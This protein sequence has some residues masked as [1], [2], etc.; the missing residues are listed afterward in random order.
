VQSIHVN[1]QPWPVTWTSLSNWILRLPLAP[2]P[3]GYWCKAS[4]AAACRCPAQSVTLTIEFTG[5]AESPVGKVLF[6]EIMF[7]PRIADAEYVELFNASTSATFDLSGWR[8]NGLDYT[9]PTGSR[10]APRGFLVLVKDFVAYWTA[11]GMAVPAFDSFPGNLQSDGETLTLIRPGATPADDLVVDRVTYAATLPWPESAAGQGA[12]LQLIDPAQ[13]NSRVGNWSDNAPRWRFFSFT[14]NSGSVTRFSRFSLYFDN[15]GQACLDDVALVSGTVPGV[16][17][18][19]LKN[20][21]FESPLSPPWIV[22]P[23]GLATNSAITHSL[24][25]GGAASLL[26]VNAASAGS[27]THFYQYLTNIVASACR[28]TRIAP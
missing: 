25:H 10:I 24:A 4:T 11:Y 18:N 20:G 19:Y 27:V 12:A 17:T 15:G 14:G 3:Q 16:G 2:G 1:D 5:L 21:D 8:I 23:S 13:D 6:S 26:L 7:A 9:F 22:N 28:Q